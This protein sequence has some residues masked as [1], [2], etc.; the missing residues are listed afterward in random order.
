M[1]ISIEIIPPLR[2]GGLVETEDFIS[3]ILD[4]TSLKQVNITTHRSTASLTK[5]GHVISGSV[6]K[7][8]PSTIAVAAHLK[9][10]FD[11]KVVPHIIC[12]GFS[13]SETESALIDLSYL[14]IEDIFCIRGD[15]ANYE[16]KYIRHPDGFENSLDLIRYVNNYTNNGLL[17]DGTESKILKEFSIGAAAYPG[18]RMGSLNNKRDNDW[19]LNK[20]NAGASYFITQMCWDVE[21]F[22]SLPT[23]L[24]IY[25]GIKVLKSV[26]QAWAVADSF[27]VRVPENILN[28]VDEGKT[29][30]VHT[31]LCENL[32]EIYKHLHFYCTVGDRNVLTIVKNLVCNHTH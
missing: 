19:L 28:A 23:E 1:N 12:S 21:S 8:R 22:R 6:L 24:K 17:F 14:G 9:N 30:Q 11:L 25:P 26:R 13:K 29:I 32:Y 2:T 4:I 27:G 18:G 3:N 10:K 31:E 20:Y 5:D 7:H 16:P 15:K